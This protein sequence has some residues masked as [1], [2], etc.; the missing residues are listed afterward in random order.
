M[1]FFALRFDLRN[2]AFA[3]VSMTER[4]QAALDMSE[5]ADRLGFVAITLSEHHGV[6]DGYLPSPLTMAAMIFLAASYTT[7]L[8]LRRLERRLETSP[9]A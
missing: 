5:W 9:A 4:Y 2:P 7:A 6:D 3:G 8:G 1:P